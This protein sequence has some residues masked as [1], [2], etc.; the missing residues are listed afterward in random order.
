MKYLSFHI[1]L[2]SS[3]MGFAQYNQNIEFING[4]VATHGLNSIDSISFDGDGSPVYNLTLTD[5]TILEYTLESIEQVSF[6]GEA[7]HP[8]PVET[9]HCIPIGTQIV[10]VVNP[11]TGRTWMDRNLGAT[12]QATSPT[13]AQAYGDLY[14]WGRF[15]DGHQCRNSE[16]TVVQATS[17]MPGHDEFVIEFTN[18]FSPGNT[19]LWQGVSGLNTP[20]PLGFRVPTEFEWFEEYL[21]WAEG[22]N[23]NGAFAS[24]L[25]LPL[26]GERRRLDGDIVNVGLESRYW[27]SSISSG[28]SSMRLVVTESSVNVLGISRSHGSS[29]RCIKD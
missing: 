10:E 4:T 1:A 25:K 18:W 29:V 5:G 12:Q 22:F 2:C 20:C 23:A 26:A 19:S 16:I 3:L 14:Q 11:M 17:S 15:S 28:N 13:D 7:L 6:D 8:F 24:P 9:V 21:S 27:S